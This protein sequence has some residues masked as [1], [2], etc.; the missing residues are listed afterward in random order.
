M[1][2]SRRSVLAFVF[3]GLSAV[4]LVTA[5]EPGAMGP[6]APRSGPAV[7]AQTQGTPALPAHLRDR[8]EGLP[9]SMFGTYIR[10]GEWIVYPFFEYYRDDDFE[11]KPEEFGYPGG[12]D[13]LGR[14]RASEGLLFLAYGLGENV[15]IEVE[16]AYISASF[17]KAADDTSGLPPRLE[18]SGLGDVEG[19]IRWRWNRENERRPELFSYFEAVIPHSQDKALI[20][21][22][23]WEFKLGTGIVKGFGW[24][25]LTARV[26]VDYSEASSSHFDLGEYAIEYL[27]RL[28]PRFRVYLGLEGTQDELSLITEL[29]WHLGRNAF[30]RLNN[31]LGLTSKAADWTPEVGIVFTLPTRRSQPAAR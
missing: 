12:S 13:H 19:Q 7:A 30:V 29:Q 20:G 14:Y 23:G 10:R 27:K 31:G 28:S 17:E 25:T 24:G 15:A 8:G 22:S 21:T 1:S 3:T 9:T 2:T 5:S 4:P 6:P 11:Y 16:A 18:E 26:A